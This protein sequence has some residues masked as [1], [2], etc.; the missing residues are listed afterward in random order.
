MNYRAFS[1]NTDFFESL[2]K[3]LEN[4]KEKIYIETYIFREDELG[5]KIKNILI[6]KSKNGCEVKLLIDAI[7][8]L[9]ISELNFSD[10]IA[11]KGDVKFF[12]RILLL[13]FHLAK[14]NNR[15]HRK[16]AVID[17]NISYIGSTN[18]DEQTSSWRE[19]NLRIENKDFNH[20]FSRI[21]IDQFLISNSLILNTDSAKEIHKI[22]GIEILR[23]VPFV[24][25]SVREAFLDLIRNAR[26]SIVIENPYIV[27]DGEVVKSLR[28]ALRRKVK[29]TIILPT[30]SDHNIVDY[31]NKKYMRKLKKMGIAILM[32][33]KMLHSKIILIDNKQW[34]FGSANFEYRSMFTQFEVMMKGKEGSIGDLI[35]K[36]ISETLEETKGHG[37]EFDGKI[38]FLEQVIGNLLYLVRF[39]F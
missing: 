30:R 25:H 17:D 13:P 6:E 21:F 10:L 1:I 16:I 12:R 34:M 11:S 5:Q 27:F 4:A 7:G 39:L 32:Y 38:T 24:F 31:L 15:N 37:K 33:P 35:T 2:V 14:L 8:S 18:I 9:T 22:D 28:K 36:H 23:A 20:I 29:I 26:E 19:F 3:D